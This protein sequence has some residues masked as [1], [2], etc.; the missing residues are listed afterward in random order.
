MLLQ[1][2]K[3]SCQE[4]VKRLKEDLDNL[5]RSVEKRKND[6]KEFMEKKALVERYIIQRH[7]T[8][9]SAA[10]K[11]KDV[12]LAEVEAKCADMKTSQ[13]L[14]LFFCFL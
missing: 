4:S 11:Y 5:E 14:S 3:S 7:A 13:Y 9:I 2:P 8:L 12:E 10:D 1:S 6:L